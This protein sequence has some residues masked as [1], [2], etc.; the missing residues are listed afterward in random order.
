MKGNDDSPMMASFIGEVRVHINTLVK[1]DLPSTATAAEI[2]GTAIHMALDRAAKGE[3]RVLFADL[4]KIRR[5]KGAGGVEVKTYEDN[6]GTI[7][8]ETAERI[9]LVQV[10]KEEEREEKG[11]YD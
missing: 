7:T 3:G 10:R 8:I 1:F 6:E 2:S 9:E 5:R 11:E 4:G